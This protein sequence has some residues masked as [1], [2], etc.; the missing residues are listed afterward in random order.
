MAPNTDSQQ[1]PTFVADAYILSLVYNGANQTS[2][3]GTHNGVDYDFKNQF[4]PFTKDET[5]E[6]LSLEKKQNFKDEIRFCRAN[7]KFVG[8]STEAKRVLDAFARCIT[9]TATARPT[10]HKDHPEL[11]V[12]RWD[13]GYRQLKGL[14]EDA[15]P[16]AFKELKA[17]TK[18]LKEKML[19]QVYELGFLKK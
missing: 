4:F 16:E 2:I 14:F 8:H 18:A 17:A 19:P 3:K 11:Q 6:M 9:E 15:A 13:A 5:Y 12:N 1:Y 7:N 10:Y